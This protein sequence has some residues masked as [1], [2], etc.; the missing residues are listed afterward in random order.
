MSPVAMSQRFP[1]SAGHD[2]PVPSSQIYGARHGLKM[3]RI[4]TSPRA[5]KVIYVEAER[6]RAAQLLI[7][8]AMT[9]QSFAFPS[10]Y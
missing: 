5:T 1:S 4:A 6:N 8:K 3:I 9:K 7:N 10:R 2:R